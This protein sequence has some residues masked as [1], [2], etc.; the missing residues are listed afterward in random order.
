MSPLAPRGQGAVGHVVCVM[1]E[2]PEPVWQGRNGHRRSVG[3]P[4]VNRELKQS[5]LA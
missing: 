5:R 2:F 1:R 3:N 4:E